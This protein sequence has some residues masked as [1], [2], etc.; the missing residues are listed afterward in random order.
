M[1]SATPKSY[2]WKAVRDSV[3]FIFVAGPFREPKDIP[4]TV[5]QASAGAAAAAELLAESR[6]TEVEEKSYPP[7]KNVEDQPPRVGVFVC[8]CGI[9]I[10]GTVRV[11][12]VVEYAKTL[13]EV[14]YVQDNLVSCSTDAQAQ[15]IDII[16]QQNLNRVVISACSPRTHEPLFQETLRNSS[17]NKYL[18]EQANIRDQCSWVHA[19]DR[20]AATDK[21][22]D[23]DP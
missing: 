2:F 10:G 14:V 1:P 20:D 6:W 13:P 4:E 8:H 12:Q 3:P 5:M 17:L 15:L 19:G 9:N 23:I 7:E 16:K 21:A 11:P 22:K 18:F